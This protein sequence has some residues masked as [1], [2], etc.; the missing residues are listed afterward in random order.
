M[1]GWYYFAYEHG[2]IWRRMNKSCDGDSGLLK[3]NIIFFPDYY[4]YYHLTILLC[5]LA[6]NW[7]NFGVLLFICLRGGESFGKFHV[8]ILRFFPSQYFLYYTWIIWSLGSPFFSD[9]FPLPRARFFF[10]IWQI[11]AL[12][13]LSFFFQWPHSFS[14]NI[15]IT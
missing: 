5:S 15:L 9:F 4:R 3:G 2:A 14:I 6:E 7:E 8:L 11:W 12:D 1:H 10:I 13:L